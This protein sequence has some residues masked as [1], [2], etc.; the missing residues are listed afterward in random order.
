MG[1]FCSHEGGSYEQY[2]SYMLL[3][4]VVCHVNEHIFNARTEKQVT[5]GL[6]RCFSLALSICI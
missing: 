5:K 2:D 6:P 3:F 1:A 4:S